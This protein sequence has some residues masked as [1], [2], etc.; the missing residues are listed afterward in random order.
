VQARVNKLANKKQNPLVDY[1]S[2]HFGSEPK[3]KESMEQIKRVSADLH[4]FAEAL[5]DKVQRV[6]ALNDFSEQ[7]E[8]KHTRLFAGVMVVRAPPAEKENT[9][10]NTTTGK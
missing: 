9:R 7:H 2:L 1:F 4:E 3:E 6:E 10:P 5:K 8:E